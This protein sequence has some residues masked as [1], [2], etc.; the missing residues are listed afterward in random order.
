MIQSD[1]LSLAKHSLFLSVE[2]SA[3][4]MG[5]QHGMVLKDKIHFNIQE[6]LKKKS[7]ETPLGQNKDR[8]N[9]FLKNLPVL[10]EHIPDKYIEEMKGIAKGADASFEDILLLNLFPEL[11][12]CCGITLSKTASKDG[13]LYHVRVLDYAAGKG[14]QSSAVLLMAKPEKG[15]PFLNAT[16]AGFIGSVTGMNEEK[17]SIGEIGGKG[18]GSWDGMPMAFLLRS[19]LE[20]ANSLE[21]AKE[22]LSSA[23]RTCEY[24]YII[25]DGKTEDSFACY[26]TKSDLVF[27][28]PG[29]DYCLTPSSSPEDPLVVNIQEKEQKHS[30]YFKQPKD[31]LLVTGTS[32]PERYPVLLERIEQNL[33]KLDNYL[34]E[35]ILQKPVSLDSNLH[36]VIFHPS[37]LTLW[38][39]HASSKGDPAYTQ[40]YSC[41]K[42]QDLK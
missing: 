35:K 8:L 26:A 7:E 4:E 15:I 3:F 40:P 19:I 13:S 14:L 9:A 21:K 23:K 6:Y 41:F 39:S 34:L 24:Y 36:N 11:F 32:S 37:S 2:G 12:H 33:G 28:F 31:V 20:E 18:Y 1:L 27:L 22:L 38:I 29:K 17:I 5:L 42:F 16:Y 25:A 30:L 10:L